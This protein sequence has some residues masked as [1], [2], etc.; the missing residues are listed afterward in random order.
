MCRWCTQRFSRL[1]FDGVVKGA[2]PAARPF[3]SLPSLS[4]SL[5]LHFCVDD[6]QHPILQLVASMPSRGPIAAAALV[7]ERLAGG[8]RASHH[9]VLCMDPSLLAAAPLQ[10]V[11][12]GSRKRLGGKKGRLSALFFFLLIFICFGC[13][14]DTEHMRLAIIRSQGKNKRFS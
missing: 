3:P 1:L 10:N 13:R 7:V 11:R 5:S 14:V 8:K 12:K 9:I 4:L 2:V 6:M